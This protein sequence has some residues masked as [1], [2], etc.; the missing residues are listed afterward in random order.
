MNW[1]KHDLT[2]EYYLEIGVNLI[3]KHGLFL[4]RFALWDRFEAN[5]SHSAQPFLILTA[6][7]VVK[8]LTEF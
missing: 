3:E 1:P 4:E 6:I 2:N 5:S 8:Y 7:V